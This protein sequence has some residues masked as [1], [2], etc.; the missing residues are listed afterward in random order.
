MR[1]NRMTLAS[2]VALTC[3]LVIW[4]DVPT[5][6]AQRSGG[7][8]TGAARLRPGSWSQQRASRSVRHARDYARGIYEH[9]RD[10]RSIPVDIARA[11]SEEL[12][13]NIAKAQQELQTVQQEVGQ[14]PT[15]AASLKTIKEHLSKAATE[16][17]ML[18]KECEKE[19]IDESACMKHCN[20]I[21][22]ELDKAQAE[23]DALLRIME[24][25]ERQQQ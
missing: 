11:E 20:Q 10:A 3:A 7:G 23:H 6:Q 24:I 8:V 18:H 1:L 12:G 13:R 5:A 2:I 21:L 14:E 22:L 17:A 19:S 4:G 9:S 25:Q 16:H 15:A